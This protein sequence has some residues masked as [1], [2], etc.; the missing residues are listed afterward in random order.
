M[1]KEKKFQRSTERK[2]MSIDEAKIATRRLIAT[3][4][5]PGPFSNKQNRQ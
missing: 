1:V 2:S 4:T 5:S 3:E